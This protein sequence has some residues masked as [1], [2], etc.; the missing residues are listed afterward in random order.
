M[1][2]IFTGEKLTASLRDI[3]EDLNKERQGVLSGEDSRW[4]SCLFLC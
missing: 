2:K 1:H 3:K 4:E